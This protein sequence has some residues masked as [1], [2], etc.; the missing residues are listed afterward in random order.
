MNMQKYG[1]NFIDLN[2]LAEVKSISVFTLRKYARKEGMPH[3]RNGQ[4]I[5]VD[6]VEFDKW[7]LTKNSGT[8]NNINLDDLLN[9][10]LQ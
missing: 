6:P 5:L 3:C 8:K 2:T 1:I 7:F 4:K 9:D 10:V